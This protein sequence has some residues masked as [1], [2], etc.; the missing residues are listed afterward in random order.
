[1]SI[2]K[3][4][5]TRWTVESDRIT[6]YPYGLYFIVSV[7]LAILVIGFTIVVYIMEPYSFD[8]TMTYLIPFSIVFLALFFASG[9]THIIFDNSNFT[10]TK[11]WMG[12]IPVVTKSFDQLHSINVM[13][14]STGGFNFRMYPKDNKF[15]KGI[16]LSSYYAKDTHPNCV[17]FTNEVIPLIHRYLDM[18][19]PL[20]EQKEIITEYQYFT[21]SNGIYTYKQHRIGAVLFVIVCLAF[22][23]H[24]CTPYAYSL[25]KSDMFRVFMIAVP[26]LFAGIF[27][28]AMFMNIIFDTK[29]RMVEKKSPAR[30]GNLK[31]PFE[32]FQNFHMIRKT[33]NGAYSGTEVHMIFHEPGAKNTKSL[34]IRHVRNTKKIDRLVDEIKSIMR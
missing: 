21:E 3:L 24:E 34:L 9:Y 11:K 33:T 20:K 26:L 31:M 13:R 17:A 27:L 29:T 23:I 14:Q 6:I 18:S 30:I 8:H 5:K 1:M 7:I 16:A 12:I 22:G 28:N 19:S 2:K 10:M 15:G 25:D 32:Y 4:I